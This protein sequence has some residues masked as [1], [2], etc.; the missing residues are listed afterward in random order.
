VLT[1]VF[2][3][4]LT[5]VIV[6]F[7]YGCCFSTLPIGFIVVFALFLLNFFSI[8]VTI[9]T[10]IYLTGVCYDSWVTVVLKVVFYRRSCY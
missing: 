7:F 4:V 1:I 8:F 10:V 6:D 5:I 2:T 9:V 3:V